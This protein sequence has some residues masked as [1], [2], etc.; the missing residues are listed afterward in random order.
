MSYWNAYVGNLE[1]HG[2]G[3][4]FDPRLDDAEKYPVAART[5]QGHKQDGEDGISGKLP[6]PSVSGPPMGVQSA[7]AAARALLSP[8]R[9][10]NRRYRDAYQ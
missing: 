2:K 4:F 7:A 9:G 5:R 6:A 8:Q 3:N 10:G 1:M